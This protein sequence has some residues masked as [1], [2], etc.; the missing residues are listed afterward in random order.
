MI[1]KKLF[2]IVGM[3]ILLSSF[4]IA[5]STLSE[6]SVCCEKTLDGAFC[7]NTE[8][9]QCNPAFASSPTSCETTSYCRL[10]TCY[11]S[12]EGI[13]MENTPQ[14]VCDSSGGT[15]DSREIEEVAQCQ[16]GCCIIA[17]QA[18]FVPLVRCKQLSTYFG[19]ENNYDPSVTSEVACIALAQSQDKG[20]CVF[21]KDFERTC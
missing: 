16:L 17:D 1:N 6:P 8:S 18:A 7:V 13:C 9:S 20:A 14:N 12:G 21:E 2:L 10:G 11:D 4:A 5:P 15:W 19:V 3:L